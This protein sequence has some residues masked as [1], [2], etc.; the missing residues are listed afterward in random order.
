MIIFSPDRVL[1]DFVEDAGRHFGTEV[2]HFG[3]TLFDFFFG[4]G[5]TLLN[6]FDC[7]QRCPQDEVP[8]QLVCIT[9]PKLRHTLSYGHFI[10]FWS[11]YFALGAED[12]IT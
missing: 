4:G 3:S 8:T 10:A 11:L 2:L 1:F 12:G 6:C 7:A 5:G 9:S